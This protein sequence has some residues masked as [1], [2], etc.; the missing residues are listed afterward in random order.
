MIHSHVFVRAHNEG[1]YFK[2]NIVYFLLKVWWIALSEEEEGLLLLSCAVIHKSLVFTYYVVIKIPPKS[3]TVNYYFCFLMLIKTK[4]FQPP[5]IFWALPDKQITVSKLV[6]R[7][8]PNSPH[9]L[10]WSTPGPVSLENL[11]HQST[12]LQHC[13]ADRNV[14]ATWH[15]QRHFFRKFNLFFSFLTPFPTLPHSKSL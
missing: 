11:L 8:H 2:D 12:V 15:K 1:N 13:F 3:S 10:Q 9:Y 7:N 4:H 6:Y 5:T 14:I